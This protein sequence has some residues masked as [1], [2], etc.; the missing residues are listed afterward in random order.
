MNW[1]KELIKDIVDNITDPEGNKI[2]PI[3]G[4]GVYH[5]FE[6]G[7]KYTLQEFLVKKILESEESPIPNTPE[8]ITK[9]STGYRGMSNLY[10]S[11]GDKFP[12]IV[13]NVLLNDGILAKVKLEEEVLSFLRNGRF[14]LILTTCI[15]RF[16]EDIKSPVGTN[17]NNIPYRISNCKD[18]D[19]DLSEDRLSYP[20]LYYLFGTVSPSTNANYVITE[21]DFLKYINGLLDTQTRPICLKRYMEDK[22]ILALGCE[23]PDWVFRFLLYSLKEKNEKL[24]GSRDN[25]TF[26]GGALSETLDE[27]LAAFLSD[28]SYF[29]DKELKLF[30]KEINSLLSPIKRPKVFLSVNSEDYN[31]IGDKIR[32]ILSPMF[33]VWYFKDNGS[34]MYWKSIKKGIEECDFFIPVTT[35]Y[36]IDKFSEEQPIKKPDIEKGIVTE[37]RYALEILKKKGQDKFCFPYLV[38]I[39]D[40]TLKRALDEKGNCHDL[41]DLFYSGVENMKYR[42]EELT[43]EKVWNHIMK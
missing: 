13:K 15:F 43:A 32:N 25:K 28:I 12:R 31:S 5:A 3:I 2:V 18:Q 11:F 35:C 33:D 34:T 26:D 10:K 17:Y 8:N 14:P 16:K 23:I 4:S 7:K 39:T 40:A 30:L 22:N 29:S 9:F 42:L 36:S 21:D 1:S 6:D 37:L 24:V 41:F 38:G 19:L 27:N 20:T